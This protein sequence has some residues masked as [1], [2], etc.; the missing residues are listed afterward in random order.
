M[1]EY[2][3]LQQE[4]QNTFWFYHPI[5]IQFSTAMKQHISVPPIPAFNLMGLQPQLQ[6]DVLTLSFILTRVQWRFMEG[7]WKVHRE[8]HR[9]VESDKST[10]T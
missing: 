7:S 5:L 4:R 8:V 1:R 9:E 2:G 10:L 6:V 3:T